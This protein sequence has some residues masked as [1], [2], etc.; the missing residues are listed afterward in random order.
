VFVCDTWHHI[1][2]RPQYLALL[3][4]ALKP[5]GRIAVVDF[6]AV[7]MPVGPPPEMRLSREAVVAEFAK[8]GFRLAIEHE[9][10]P[11]QYFLVFA[12]VPARAGTGTQAE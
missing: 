9:F 2:N 11:Y 8:G 12:P 10:L 6:R 3:K 7:A 4:A 1:G 5:G